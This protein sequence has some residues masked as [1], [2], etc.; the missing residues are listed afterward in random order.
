MKKYQKANLQC[1]A[2]LDCMSQIL[3]IKK[4]KR[5]S[6]MKTQMIQKK[7]KRKE[8]ELK[9]YNRKLILSWT[10]MENNRQ[11]QSLQLKTCHYWRQGILAI[12]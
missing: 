8:K 12:M 11:G 5:L 1:P 3:T 2:R 4:T 7:K 9:S 6:I 10:H